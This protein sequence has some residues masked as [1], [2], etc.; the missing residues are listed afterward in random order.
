MHEVSPQIASVD[1]SVCDGLLG[2]LEGQDL[3]GLK[4]RF[5]SWAT[6]ADWRALKPFFTGD[7]V[8][9]VDTLAGVQAGGA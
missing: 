9:M 6:P 8:K 4:H 7:F 2:P 1:C 5:C 3:I